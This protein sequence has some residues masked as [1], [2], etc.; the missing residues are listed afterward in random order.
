[1]N[2][3]YLLISNYCNLI[4]FYI[5]EQ[6]FNI[7]LKEVNHFIKILFYFEFF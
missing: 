2:D 4:R 7:T 1:M 3:Y 5:Y 6:F